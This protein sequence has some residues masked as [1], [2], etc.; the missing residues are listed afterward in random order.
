[1]G[2][3][4]C[5]WAWLRTDWGWVLEGVAFSAEGGIARGPELGDL[6]GAAS[7]GR[8]YRGRG[9]VVGVALCPV[10]LAECRAELS[11]S[12]QNLCGC[13]GVSGCGAGTRLRVAAGLRTR[14]GGPHLSPCPPQFSEPPLSHSLNQLPPFK[15]NFF[16]VGGDFPS[17]QD[18]GY[19][20]SCALLAGDPLGDLAGDSSVPRS[21]CS[22]R[23][24]HSP[25]PPSCNP[26]S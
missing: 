25:H 7:R 13:I 19:R 2:A 6:I 12:P 24:R 11:S 20:G 17:N 5:A 18:A 4:H 21:G 23:R 3:W 1:M 26:D 8:G 22:G 15:K 14:R 10:P 16:L 9:L